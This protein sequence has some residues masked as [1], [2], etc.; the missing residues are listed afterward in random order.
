MEFVYSEAGPASKSK[1]LLFLGEN[2]ERE[3]HTGEFLKLAEI[4]FSRV[5]AWNINEEYKLSVGDPINDIHN[6]LNKFNINVVIFALGESF[7]FN[8]RELY[9]LIKKS[10]KVKF[11]FSFSDS[12]HAFETCDKYYAQLSD[13]VWIPSPGMKPRFEMFQLAVTVGQVFD[14]ELYSS[15]LKE[16]HS[17][18]IDISFIGGVYRSDRSLLLETI[19]ENGYKIYIAGTGTKNGRLG[20]SEKNSAIRDSKIHLNFCGVVSNTGGID[21][22]YTQFKGRVV[23]SIL[24]G[25]FP[26]SQF[27]PSLYE[28]FGDEL[29]YFYDSTDMVNAISIGLK[30]IDDEPERIDRLREIC[31]HYFDPERIFHELATKKRLKLFRTCLVDGDFKKRYFNEHLYLIGFFLSQFRVSRVYSEFF[32]ILFHFCPSLS[33]IRSFLRGVRDGFF[34]K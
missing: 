26:V 14:F 31:F 4:Y 29:I 13:L 24:L 5:Y 12:E 1:T 10:E 32:K 11:I 27:D 8:P 15:F 9:T 19:L 6:A 30:I 28:I 20:I 22:R 33:N 25:T 17:K 18:K 7:L 21:N 34:K 23:E 2:L 16:D 3:S